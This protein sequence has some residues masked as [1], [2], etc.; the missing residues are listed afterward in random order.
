MLPYQMVCMDASDV[1]MYLSMEMKI[2][3]PIQGQPGLVMPKINRV[4][5]T[6]FKMNKMY[7]YEISYKNE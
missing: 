3:L 7:K 2:H 5:G 4:Q 1:K 6:L